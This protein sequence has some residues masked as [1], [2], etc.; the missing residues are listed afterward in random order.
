MRAARLVT[1]MLPALLLL[2]GCARSR[3]PNVLL[4]TLDTTRADH[5][6]AYGAKDAHTPNLD[7]LAA[8]GWLFENARTVCPLTLPAHASILTGVTPLR[9][10]LRVNEGGTLP[11]TV[12]T[13]PELFRTNGYATAAFVAAVVLDRRFGLDRGFDHYDD[14]L[15]TQLYGAAAES[16]P[17]AAVVPA[18]IDGTE[19]TAR[20]LTWLALRKKPWFAWVHY[21]DPHAP[22]RSHPEY[23]KYGVTNAYAQEISHMDAQLGRIVAELRRRRQYRDTWIIAV[24]D[25]GESLGEHG[26]MTHGMTVY[27]PAI[28]VPLIVKTA[29]RR[30]GRGRRESRPVS[31]VDI[32]ATLAEA[33]GVK[34]IGT[35]PLEQAQSLFAREDAA[36]PREVYFETLNPETEY[37]WAPLA[38]VAGREWKFIES[39]RPELY[40]LL[41]DPNELDNRAAR[42]DDLVEAMGDRVMRRRTNVIAEEPIPTALD[43]ATLARFASLGYLAGGGAGIRAAAS[44]PA[45]TNDTRRDV[46]DM[47]P[48]VRTYH[49]LR[50]TFVS[51]QWGTNQLAIARSLCDLSP[52]TLSFQL[53]L[54]NMAASAGD[55][56]L[57]DSV[58]RAACEQSLTD[59]ALAD[60]YGRFLLL[61]GSY[62]DARKHLRR[63]LDLGGGVDFQPLAAARLA[64]AEL[65][66]GD[67]VAATNLLESALPLMSERRGT[68]KRLGD[69][70]NLLGDPSGALSC[71]DQAIRETEGWLPAI[72]GRAW[73][74][75]CAGTPH[76]RRQAQAD[77]HLLCMASDHREPRDLETMAVAYAAN[78]KFEQAIE[79]AEQALDLLTQDTPEAPATPDDSTRS[80]TLHERWKRR[81]DRT[82]YRA[83]ITTRLTQS[84]LAWQERQL[85]TP[86]LLR[87]RLADRDYLLDQPARH[88]PPE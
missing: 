86:A 56:Q 5:V 73:T 76:Q 60:A 17:A 77:A 61:R 52:E 30:S 18:S 25:H 28:R 6:G 55:D 62:E 20:A 19:V 35:E 4:V 41:R 51:G 45:S 33:I 2:A 72:E 66:F 83:L 57:A 67:Y 79:T 49:E 85:P 9:H 59:S 29:N 63:G 42:D 21:Y 69:C 70:R 12:P 1:A 74:A 50:G 13:L 81:L 27:E 34:W 26:E 78:G 32:P 15:P 71:Y 80:S 11:P 39:P 46:K 22:Y 43:A 54:A 88:A 75:A 24:G 31:V 16:D 37:G 68:L 48:L 14:R 47:L 44:R 84:R 3:Q 23:E 40:E 10:G 53:L 38:G 82:P 58:F 8:D 87:T 7:R 64:Q 65:G 36:Q